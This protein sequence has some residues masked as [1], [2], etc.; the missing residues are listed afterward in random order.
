MVAFTE[1]YKQRV[2]MDSLDILISTV[3][4]L[5]RCLSPQSQQFFWGQIMLQ[6][7]NIIRYFL[8]LLKMFCNHTHIHYETIARKIFIIK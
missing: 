6:M 8:F 2:Q 1:M 7:E 5:S 4:V 3:C